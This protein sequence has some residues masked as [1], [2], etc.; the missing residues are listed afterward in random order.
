MGLTSWERVGANDPAYKAC[1]A[2]TVGLGAVAGI[3]AGSAGAAGTAGA[4][5]PFMP[6]LMLKGAALGFAAGYFACP[7]LAPAIRRKFELGQP[8]DVLEVRTAAEAMGKYA[9]VNSA[10]EAVKLV[11]MARGLAAGA[12]GQPVCAAPAQ[13]ARDLL[14]SIAGPTG[15]RLA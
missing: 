15:G 7:F 4:L 2:G 6:A 11:A 9:G 8:L 13:A 14:G 3:I 1:M 12:R 10:P 5:T